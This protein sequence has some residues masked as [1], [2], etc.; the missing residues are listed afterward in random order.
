MAKSTPA[1]RCRFRWNTP[2][3]AGAVLVGLTLAL[4]AGCADFSARGRNAEGVRLFSSARYHEALQ[5][6]QEAAFTDPG[7]ADGNYNLAA[8]YHRL[9]LL[10]NDESYLRQAEHHYHLCLDQGGNHADCYRGLAVL[11]VEQER[12][13]E[14][15]RLLE[16]WV[17]REPSSAEAKIELARLFEEFGDRPAAKEHLL[18]ALQAE[19]TN[20]RALAALGKIREDMGEPIQALAD[21]ERSL[22]H[23]RFQPQVA[24]RIAALRSTTSPPLSISGPDGTTRLVDRES[25]SLR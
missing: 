19:P 8:T 2:R 14:A 18:E 7:N 23:D 3:T 10:E 13:E 1:I 6:F 4:A 15:F 5:Q 11:L 21:Y 9:G 17:D 20:P 25:Q 16:G 24:S 12:N 22:W